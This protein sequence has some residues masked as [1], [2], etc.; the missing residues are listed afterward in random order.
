MAV[1]T[2]IAVLW[3]VTPSSLVFIYQFFRGVTFQKMIV[4]IISLNLLNPLLKI[5]QELNTNE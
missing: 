5:L 3:D 4:F 2:Q 1:A